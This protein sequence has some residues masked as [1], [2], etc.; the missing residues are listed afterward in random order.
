M[1]LDFTNVASKYS[2]LNSKDISLL[3][4][5]FNQKEILDKLEEIEKWRK[6]IFK[7]GTT[8]SL[9]WILA[10]W[11]ITFLWNSQPNLQNITWFASI[12]IWIVI[13]WTGI[14]LNYHYTK[15][16]IK[17][18]IMPK[19]VEMLHKDI[20][21]SPAGWLLDDNTVSLVEK[22]IIS[23][24]DREDFVEDSI[25]FNFSE[26][27]TISWAEIKTSNK[28]TTQTKNGTQTRYVVN[29]HCYVLKIQYQNPKLML[30]NWIRL[31]RDTNENYYYMTLIPLLPTIFI[32]WVS[33]FL[34]TSNGFHF[35]IINYA[36]LA[37]IFYVIF[38]FL[39]K[40]IKGKNRTKMENNEFEKKFDVYCED[41]I[42]SRMILTPSFMFRILDYIKKISEN[43]VYEFHFYEDL[44]YIKFDILHSWIGSYMEFSMRQNV[45]ENLAQY[46]EFYVE[47]K[48]IISLVED[49][50]LIYLDKNK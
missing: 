43:R 32:M 27:I 2:L 7:I 50:N 40:H 42:E 34:S 17:H 19:F 31:K 44:I 8:V 20:K 12:G 10:I 4:N 14:W 15:V 18:H 39:T 13:I 23:H 36:I 37:V 21:Y 28:H 5:F 11:I 9:L 38:F 49:L 46:V 3:N 26:G 24:Y 45:K 33:V 22:K 1:Q 30:K 6:M 35:D 41:E 47:I 25:K 29:N 48:N 16:N